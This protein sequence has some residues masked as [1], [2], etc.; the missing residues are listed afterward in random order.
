[1]S[2]LRPHEYDRIVSTVHLIESDQTYTAHIYEY[3]K[4]VKYLTR[5]RSGDFLNP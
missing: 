2:D 3:A 4:D 1:M 5:I